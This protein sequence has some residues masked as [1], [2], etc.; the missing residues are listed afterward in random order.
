MAQLAHLMSLLI[1]QVEHVVLIDGDVTVV[2]TATD[3]HAFV[4][5]FDLLHHLHVE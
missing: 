2:T 1:Q 3:D 5:G 4:F